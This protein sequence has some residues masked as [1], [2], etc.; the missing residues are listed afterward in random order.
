MEPGHG[1]PKEDESDLSLCCLGLPETAWGK[2]DSPR[3]GRADLGSD[4][5]L[6]LTECPLQKIITVQPTV[7]GSDVIVEKH[8]RVPGIRFDTHQFYQY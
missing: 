1:H 2:K 6:P 8:P 5:P 4:P 7:F 3:I